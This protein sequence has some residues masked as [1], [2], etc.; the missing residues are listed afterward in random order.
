MTI[1][2]VLVRTNAEGRE[3]PNQFALRYGNA[4]VAVDQNIASFTTAAVSPDAL[5]PGTR[6]LDY[7][8]VYT[9]LGAGRSG[10]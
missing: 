9:V 6:A 5:P 10:R 4:D 8:W 3:W 1:G 7:L 2:S